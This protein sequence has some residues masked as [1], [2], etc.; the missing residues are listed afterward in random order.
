MISSRFDTQACWQKPS[1]APQLRLCALTS[2]A[3]SQFPV[4]PCAEEH[5]RKR[6]PGTDL[7]MALLHLTNDV[8]MWLLFVLC[9][10]ILPFPPKP[11]PGQ[12]CSWV[13]L[14]APGELLSLVLLS[15]QADVPGSAVPGAG[16]LRGHSECPLPTMPCPLCRELPPQEHS[17]LPSNV[18]KVGAGPQSQDRL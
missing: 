12:V 9:S 18:S 10:L 6:F 8:H 15:L 11:F 17:S 16:W 7:G 3:V 13:H 1:S 2:T 4:I 14:M 5:H